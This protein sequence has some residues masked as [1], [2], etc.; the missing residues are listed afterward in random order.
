M[1][2]ETQTGGTAA[3][4]AEAKPNPLKEIVQPFVDVWHAPRALWA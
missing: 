3:A 4:A 1:S 2:E